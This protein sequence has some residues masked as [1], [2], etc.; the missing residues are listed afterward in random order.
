MHKKLLILY[1]LKTVPVPIIDQITQAQSY[2]HLQVNEQ[3]IA[4]NSEKYMSIRQQ[5]LRTCKR[6]GYEFNCIELFI[7]KHQVQ[8]QM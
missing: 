8:I 7:V 3:Y 2:T 1:Q 4:L 5:E 6:I